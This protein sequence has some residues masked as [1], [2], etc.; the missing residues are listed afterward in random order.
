MFRVEF[1]APEYLETLGV[2]ARVGRLFTSE[3]TREAGHGVALISEVLW[4]REFGAR[5]DVLGRAVMGVNG[6]PF[7]IV[8]VVDDYRGWGVTAANSVDVWLPQPS[9]A[10]P[11]SLMVGRVRPGVSR[12]A[13]ESRLRDVYA[14]LRATL[15]PKRSDT[16]PWVYTGLRRGPIAPRRLDVSFV[17]VLGIASLLTL[18]ACANAANLLL[19]RT[20]RR[21]QD[22]ALRAAIGA[23]RGRLM[24]SLVV[25]AIMLASI[26]VGSGLVMTAVM[27]RLLEGVQLFA[28][29]G[30]LTEISV[31]WRVV[32]F[33]AATGA[34]T[35]LI[36]ALAP[37]VSATRVDLRTVLQQASGSTRRSQRYRRA[38]VAVQIALSLGLMAGAGVV[39]QSLWNLRTIDLGMTPERVFS[40]TFHPHLIDVRGAEATALLT[41]A[42][43]RLRNSA[44][45]E[46]VGTANPSA[47]LP[48]RNEGKLSLGQGLPQVPVRVEK[49][50]VSSDYFKALGIPLIAGRTFDESE[51]HAPADASVPARI[52]N[53][54]LA[55]VLFG[56]QSAVGRHIA[57]GGRDVI[58]VGVVG[59]TKTTFTLR[60]PRPAMVFYEPTDGPFVFSRVYVRATGPLAV[61]QARVYQVMHEVEPRLP[62]VDAGTLTDEVERLIPED[63]ALAQL[64]GAIAI[65]ATLLGFGGVY[66]VTAYS[67][68]ERTREFGVRIALGAS[69][70][71]LI[72]SAG[73]GVAG[74]AVAGSVVGLV[75]YSIAAQLVA[76]RLYNV[77]SVDPVAIGG[78][79]FLLG[80]VLL[81]GALLP[82]RRVTQIDP[83]IAL[84]AD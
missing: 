81:V 15:D 52:I 1:V 58:I 48:S 72:R 7:T 68:S 5:T 67:V 29:V 63:R 61:A 51:T 8:G 59:D 60:E 39:V 28:S 2:R 69:R 12:D 41:R 45:I 77:A 80:V 79:V 47:F 71:A 75:G 19:V 33:A 27:A 16:V 34:I 42:V 55:R 30:A 53:I 35:V 6:T 38:L 21:R 66:A 65:V 17:H 11:V 10:E 44:G 50:T 78:A 3:E 20:A 74:A 49:T 4:H 83:V 32:L 54:S 23:S 64:L 76:F 82:A 56:D 40:F 24:R 14:P 46:A 62:L 18:L 25:E 26:A 13:V 73:Q 84:R 57:V 70:A 36:F 37:I 9:P 31:D 22:L 43:E